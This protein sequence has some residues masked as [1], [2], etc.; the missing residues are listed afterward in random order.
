MIKALF[1]LL[2]SLLKNELDSLKS[3]SM[4]D[5]EYASII[6]IT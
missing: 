5:S 1:I 6:M 4:T 2:K 3:W